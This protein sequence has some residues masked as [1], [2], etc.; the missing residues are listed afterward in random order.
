MDDALRL[1]RHRGA[2]L[3][4]QLR[5]FGDIAYDTDAALLKRWNVF[6]PRFNGYSVGQQSLEYAHLLLFSDDRTYGTDDAGEANRILRR[7]LDHQDLNPSSETFGNFFWMTHW[8]RV[9]DRNA[10]SFLCAGLVY[11]YLSFPN[12]LHPQTKEALEKAFP[13]M[14]A[15]I[16]KH[17][18]RWQYTNIFFLNLGGLVCLSRVLDDPSIHAEAISDFNTWLEGTST[19]GFHE[20]NSPTYTPVT[21]FG[22]EAAWALTQDTTFKARLERT[23][24]LITHQMALNMMP[25]GFLGGAPSR[26]YKPNAITGLGQA[27][28]YAHIKFGTPCPVLDDDSTTMYNNF[29]LFDYV[30][31]S[32]VRKLA[33]EKAE[34]TEIH[35]RGVSIASRRTHVITPDFGLASQCADRVGGHSPPSYILLVRKA[36]TMRKSVPFLPDESF[37]HQP[38]ATFVSRQKGTQI[39]GKLHYELAEDQRQR[40][41]NDPT[42]ICEPHVL[43]GL[44]NDI[45]E[46]RIGNVDWGGGSIH[47]HP[48]QPI[49]ISY[50]NLFLGVITQ[51]LDQSSRR[52]HLSSGD[53]G[54]LRL[55]ITIHGG[56]NLHKEDNPTDVLLF[57]DVQKPQGS[58]SD[59]ADHLTGFHLVQEN[60]DQ[61]ATQHINGTRITYPFTASDPDPLGQALHLSP[62]LTWYP[63]DLI[64]LVN[65]EQPLPFEL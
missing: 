7:I 53:D 42:Y 41:I 25:S 2:F 32:S 3:R 44:R 43:F 50:G 47:L 6:F 17:K 24:H 38:C 31:P 60:N 57:V 20:F 29:T 40:F 18:V 27:A 34:Y 52:L 8:D 51:P 4:N 59:Y 15:G 49:A 48:G 46:V 23:M 1:Q 28:V 21:L 22:L 61:F 5:A 16:R 19:D 58:L 36:N 37:L 65:R 62:N 9:K 64:K 55:C 63:G 45:V 54:E 26:A 33:T 56:P 39:V 12:K 14:L 13:N 11:A 35:D 10:V 30:P